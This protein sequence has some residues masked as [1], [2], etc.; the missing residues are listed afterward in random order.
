MVHDAI[1]LGT[2]W[3]W[4]ALV[5]DPCPLVLRLAIVMGGNDRSERISWMHRLQS[6]VWVSPGI[7]G[8]RQ[9]KVA[10]EVS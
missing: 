4:I 7:L 5:G 2:V 10:I 9:L 8:G 3:L 6:L 1:A